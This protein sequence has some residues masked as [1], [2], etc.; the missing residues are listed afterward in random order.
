MQNGLP[1]YGIPR[2][3]LVSIIDPWRDIYGR[4]ILPVGSENF[5]TGWKRWPGATWNAG[6]T[7]PESGYADPEG[8]TKAYRLKLTGSVARRIYYF[9]ALTSY[10]GTANAAIQC[11]VLSG[12]IAM[13]Q[14]NASGEISTLYTADGSWH[15]LMS[16]ATITNTNYVIGISSENIGDA[17]DVLV[18]QPQVNIGQ[19]Y[20]YAPP[21]DL[22]QSLTDYTGYGNTFQLGSAADSDTNDPQYNGVA[23]VGDGVDD[24][25]VAS[26]ASAAYRISIVDSGSG[27]TFVSEVPAYLDLF[28]TGASS[29]LKGKI[30]PTAYYNRV[31][32]AGEIAQAKAGL[33]RYMAGKGV[34]VS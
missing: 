19:L 13:T 2:N 4:N 11:K 16:N 22:P 6:T 5:V 30:G 26:F 27:Y 28:K 3:G 21:A 32:T 14:P 9:T 33:K 7:G 29:Y 17:I 23:L 12:K 34:T 10:N 20:P 25:A 15:T 18:Y 8:G 24:Y 1:P 31:L